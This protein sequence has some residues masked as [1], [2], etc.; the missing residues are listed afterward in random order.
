MGVQQKRFAILLCVLN[1][2]KKNRLAKKHQ[3]HGC[4]KLTFFVPKENHP[5]GLGVGFSVFVFFFLRGKDAF[6]KVGVL[7][8]AAPLVF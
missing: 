2:E 1:D 5:R 3:F 6:R 4:K 7:F 8:C